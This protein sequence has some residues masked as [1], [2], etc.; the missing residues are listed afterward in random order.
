MNNQV[1]VVYEEKI[2]IIATPPLQPMGPNLVTP[3]GMDV[4]QPMVRPS[5]FNLPFRPPVSNKKIK[6]IAVC[7]NL[8]T[9]SKFMKSLN[10]Y[11]VGPFTI[12]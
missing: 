11:I 2:D 3:T 7:K 5:D 8:K 9:T 6:I 10:R 1:Y 4:I 12:E